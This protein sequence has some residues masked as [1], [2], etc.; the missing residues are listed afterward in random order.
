MWTPPYFWFS[1]Y[2][3]GHNL[4]PFAYPLHYGISFQI[5]SLFNLHCYYLH[6]GHHRITTLVDTLTTAYHKGIILLNFQF[7]SL[8][9]MT[10]KMAPASN[11]NTPEA[12]V[13]EYLC[14]SPVSPTQWLPGQPGLYRET[15]SQKLKQWYVRE[16][17]N[18]VFGKD[19]CQS[20]IIRA[21][22]VFDLFNLKIL[23]QKTFT[24]VN[25]HS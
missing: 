11:T 10:A 19:V 8:A 21:F 17:W 4:V 24:E 7:S 23:G 3:F 25:F 15:L 22:I 14:S 12:K 18:S 1:P 6:G 13:G 20:S 5:H 9:Y 16:W 2:S